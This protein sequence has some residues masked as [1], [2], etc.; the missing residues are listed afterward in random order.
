M[1]ILKWVVTATCVATTLT[2]AASAKW[3]IIHTASSGEVGIGGGCA[4]SYWGHFTRTGWHLYPRN[5]AKWWIDVQ[6][7]RDGTMVLVP[8]W[9]PALMLA[10]LSVALWRRDRPIPSGRCSCCGYDLTGNVSGRCPEC[11]SA[12]G[13]Q[14]PPPM[15]P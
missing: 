3:T 15:P 8:L 9:M 10:A 12:V 2:W 13:S 11:G 1:R 5:K 4:Y 7:G 6:R 14:A